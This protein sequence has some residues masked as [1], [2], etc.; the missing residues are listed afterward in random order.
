MKV[1][2]PMKLSDRT[3]ECGCGLVMDRDLNAAINIKAAG[4]RQL[5][6]AIYQPEK[7]AA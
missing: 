6:G 7:V 5:S 1:I 3:Y 2:K 4:E